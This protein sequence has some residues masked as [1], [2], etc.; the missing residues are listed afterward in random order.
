MWE[1]A[2]EVSV[3]SGSGTDKNQLRLLCDKPGALLGSRLQRASAPVCADHHAGGWHAC[4]ISCFTL[5][6]N[7]GEGGG[8]MAFCR[9][10]ANKDELEALRIRLPRSFPRRREFRSVPLDAI[11]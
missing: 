9:K 5:N 4:R 6:G 3:H 8:G 11:R 7:D 2:R 10:G 1:A